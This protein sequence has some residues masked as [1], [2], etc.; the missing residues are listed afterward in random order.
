MRKILNKYCCI[1]FFFAGIVCAQPPPTGLECCSEY[2]GEDP[3]DPP[4][5]YLDCIAAETAEPGSYCNPVVPIDNSIYI[6]ITG[7]SGGVLVLF[8]IYRGIKHKKTPM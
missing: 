3:D 7:L 6:L 4:Q 8:V 2:E 5:Q 1:F